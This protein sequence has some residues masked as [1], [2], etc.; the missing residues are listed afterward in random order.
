ML[1]RLR[2]R[3]QLLLRALEGVGRSL[4]GLL[5]VLSQVK[6]LVKYLANGAL[7]R[8]IDW[9]FSLELATNSQ[10]PSKARQAASKYTQ[11]DIEKTEVQ[12]VPGFLPH[13][14]FP[15]PSPSPRSFPFLKKQK[16]KPHF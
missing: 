14:S 7:W 9:V 13:S 8:S 6:P 4:V 1:S 12:L 3:T 2:S 11:K 15:S 5:S 10:I 16:T